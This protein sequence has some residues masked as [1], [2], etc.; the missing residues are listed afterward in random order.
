[1]KTMELKI[2][3]IGNSHGVRIPA[4]V[5]RRYAFSEAVIM[6]ESVDGILLCPRKQTDLKMS[7]ADTAKDMAT[8]S[9][10]WSD[11]NAVASD[12]LAE[13]S[14]K[15]DRVAEKQCV[16]SKTRKMPSRR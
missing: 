7:W 9:E 16:Y 5:L 12:G 11:W 10:D 2:A 3:K 6:I 4:A 15:T 8:S 1:M 14:W 13:V